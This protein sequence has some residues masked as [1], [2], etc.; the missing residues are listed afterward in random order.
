MIISCVAIDDE[1]RALEII[2]EYIRQTPFLALKNT[3]RNPLKAFESI[4]SQ[5]ID[6][7]FLDINMPNFSGIQFIKTLSQKPLIILTTA[8]SQ[9]A[10]ESYELEVL[11][12]LLKPIEFERFIKSAN[13][14]YDL[15]TKIRN[16]TIPA[17]SL[18]FPIKPQKDFLFVKD[19]NQ[20]VKMDFCQISYIEGSG[21]YQSIQLADRKILT[22]TTMT[23]LL[24]S[25]PSSRFIRVHK[26]YIVNI[27]KI[28]SIE[29]NRI[30]ID[31]KIIPISET[32]RT[33]FYALLKQ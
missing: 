4:K 13:K 20:L 33:K 30:Y 14:A 21:N 17:N 11:D 2:E 10:V 32:Y 18:Q 16:T 29:T 24:H 26:S 23:E 6:L 28:K 19:G 12:Y 25:L 15:L 22:L 27:E 7:L 5:N 1:P 31:D 8:Y 3:F 9:Y